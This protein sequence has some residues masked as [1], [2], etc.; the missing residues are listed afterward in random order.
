MSQICFI[1]SYFSEIK[2]NKY[3]LH[4]I[5]RDLPYDEVFSCSVPC[6]HYPYCYPY[7]LHP[8]VASHEVATLAKC[9]AVCLVLTKKT[10][11]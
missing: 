1:C 10:A 3:D 7:Y 2:K 8:T 9:E 11:L 5:E 6:Y 4:A